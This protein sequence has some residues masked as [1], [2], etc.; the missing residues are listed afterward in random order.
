MLRRAASSQ[1][2]QDSALTC[3]HAKHAVLPDSPI[4]SC[5]CYACNAD[6][7]MASNLGRV[8]PSLHAA[9][10]HLLRINADVRLVTN[11]I[12]CDAAPA[13]TAGYLYTATVYL[14]TT[15]FVIAP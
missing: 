4:L 6:D 3:C 10:E 11:S 2:R 1:F 5:V 14:K 8:W 13:L 15:T 7:E 9:R 12:D